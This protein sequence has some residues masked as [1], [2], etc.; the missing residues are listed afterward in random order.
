MIPKLIAVGAAFILVSVA[1]AAESPEVSD[2]RVSLACSG[3]MVTA[4]QAPPGSRIMA[5]G[6]IDFLEMRVG[7]LGIGSAP[8]VSVTT[9]EIKFGASLLPTT[10]RGHSVEGTIDRLSGET[11]IFIR[12]AKAPRTTLIAMELDCRPT[13]LAGH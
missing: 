4:G 3:S 6:L 9:A 5:D 2:D 12:S 7:G 1:K 8:I 11:R 10:D 13:P